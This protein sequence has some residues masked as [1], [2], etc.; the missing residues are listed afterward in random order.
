MA[1]SLY[2]DGRVMPR[3]DY[4]AR[5]TIDDVPAELSEARADLARAPRPERWV[6]TWLATD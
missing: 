3:F 4:D 5:P 6:P 2:A 1:F